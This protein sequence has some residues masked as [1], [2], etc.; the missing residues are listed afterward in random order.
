MKLK[1]DIDFKEFLDAVKDC[2]GD[3]LFYTIE[4][5][6]LNLSST[7][8]R[9]IFFAVDKHEGIIRS[10]DVICKCEEDKIRLK[11]FVEQE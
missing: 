1:K 8:S 3:V 11:E 6:Q 4:G 2:R 10:G 9:I 5:D 7:I